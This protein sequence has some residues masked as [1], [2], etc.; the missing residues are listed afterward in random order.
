MLFTIVMALSVQAA[1][2]GA[3]PPA[4]VNIQR[5]IAE[6]TLGQ[7]ATARL[8]AFQ[9]ARQ[10]VIADKQAELQQLSRS[11]ARRTQIDKAELE[12][13]RLTED[14]QA[15]LTALDQQ[16]R[17]E[18]SKKLRPIVAKLAEEEHIGIIFEYPQQ[19]IVW[20]SPSVDITAK[21]IERLDAASKDQ[22]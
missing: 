7:S 3:P 1:A 8:R 10:K 17:D 19:A 9:T 12:L 2:A 15:D 14:A 6:S 11:A 13:Q 21:V 22:K 20:V 4:V 18:L 5:L 16:L